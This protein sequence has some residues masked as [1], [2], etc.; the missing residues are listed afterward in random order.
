MH[1][2]ICDDTPKDI[3]T[4]KNYLSTFQEEH[5]ASFNITE[6]SKGEALL[7]AYQQGYRPDIIFLDIYMP[8][9][10]GV[11][12]ATELKKANYSGMIIFSTTSLE[13]AVDGF[14][15]R[16]DGYLVKPYTYSQF[17]DGIWRCQEK[18][19]SSKTFLN[20]ISERISY[21]LPLAS[22]IYLEA[23]SRGCTIYTNQRSFFTYKNL[24][25]FKKELLNISNFLSI[26]Q[27]LLINMD[28]VKKILPEQIIFQNNASIYLP[29]KNKHKIRQTINH[30]CWHQLEDNHE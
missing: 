23:S 18:L 1:I 6:Y 19:L 17:L 22:L 21:E 12:I 14:K 2:A 5:K 16:A 25:L 27:S 13:H 30:Y 10:D 24:S 20:F 9:I 28:K 3:V 26:S 7:A 4:L 29:T 15:L 11:S 8:L